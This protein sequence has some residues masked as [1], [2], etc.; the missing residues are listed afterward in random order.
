MI[1]ALVFD[2]DGLILDTET[3][4]IDAWVALHEEAG[5]PY[6]RENAAHVVGHVDIPFDPWVAFDPAVDRKALEKEH[7]L[8]TRAMLQHQP[9]LPGIREY[10]ERAGAGGLKLA[11]ASNSTH[12][13]VDTHLKRLGLYEFFDAIRCRDD[14]AQGKPEPEVYLAVLA[15]LKVNPTEAIAFEDST[16]GS[17]AAKR[18]GLWCVAIPNPSTRTHDFSHVDLQ[19]NSLA[20][21]GFDALLARFSG[22]PVKG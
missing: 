13:W 16:A 18:A 7:K 14:V 11:I 22:D 10:L 19:L 5:I 6:V 15:A 20:D 4:I 1:R 3:P 21:Q 12:G 2:F 8:R 9:I 17:I